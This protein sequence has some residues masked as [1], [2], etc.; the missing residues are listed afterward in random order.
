VS[1]NDFSGMFIE[2]ATMRIHATESTYIVDDEN[3]EAI[4]QLFYFLNNS[5]L[6]KGDP[7]K[8]VLMIGAIGGGKTVLME[9][10]I[11]IF[12]EVSGKIVTLI[13]SKDLVDIQKRYGFDYL[14]RRPLFIDDIGKEQT[15]INTYGTV[16]K[17]MEDLI[18]DRYKSAGLTFG[19]SNLKLEDMPYNKHTIDRM[20][21]MFNVIILPGKT[22]R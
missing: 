14:N 4:N 3:K 22:R 5:V 18:N 13:N 16:S 20:K 8:G 7:I 11:D 21:Q 9:S 19:T 6:F 15:I 17:P 2:S 1:V 12:N 10:F